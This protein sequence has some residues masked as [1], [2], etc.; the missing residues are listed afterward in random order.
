MI[1]NVIK[2]AEEGGGC[3]FLKNEER[4]TKKIEGKQRISISSLQFLA[5][6]LTRASN[7]AKLFA[8][9]AL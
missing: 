3:K 6:A 1:V 5:E 7:Y 9:P 4:R 8:R 2:I